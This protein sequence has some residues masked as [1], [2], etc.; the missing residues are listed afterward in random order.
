MITRH[1][2]DTLHILYHAYQLL[3]QGINQT[4]VACANLSLE[5][6]SSRLSFISFLLDSQVRRTVRPIGRYPPCRRR[7]E[8]RCIL[9]AFVRCLRM[10]TAWSVAEQVPVSI[11]ATIAAGRS[12]WKPRCCGI[13]RSSATRVDSRTSDN[14]RMNMIGQGNRR[15][16]TYAPGAIAYMHF[17]H[18]CGGIRNM[19]AVW[20]RNLSAP[21]VRADSLRRAIWIVTCDQNIKMCS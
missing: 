10:R 4:D 3:S 12:L 8:S 9:G 15:R 19:S 7:R 13:R 14:L 17:S 2:W 20:N 21:S 5:P 11:C 18:R 6:V 1:V 16:N